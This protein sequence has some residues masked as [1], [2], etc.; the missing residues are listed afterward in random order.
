MKK[1]MV[2]VMLAMTAFPG[3]AF[4]ADEQP[5]A[6][7][8]AASAVQAPAAQAVEAVTAVRDEATG[9]VAAGV[10]RRQD[11]RQAI[12]P[13]AAE[14]SKGATDIA[15]SGMER[16]QARRANRRGMALGIGNTSSSQPASK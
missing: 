11:R 8:D 4:A 14:V 13:A 12:A 16:R 3:G 9:V 5:V 7:A 1:L 2:A 6:G 15:A 10:E